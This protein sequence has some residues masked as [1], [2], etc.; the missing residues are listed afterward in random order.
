MLGNVRNSAEVYHSCCYAVAEILWSRNR[1]PEILKFGANEIYD[2][3][4]FENLLQEFDNLS[5]SHIYK[6]LIQNKDQ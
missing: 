6:L 4:F 3:N 1:L 2:S 5:N